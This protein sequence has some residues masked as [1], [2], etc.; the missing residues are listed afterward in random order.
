MMQILKMLWKLFR[1][2]GTKLLWLV[3]VFVK[4]RFYAM[5]WRYGT[6]M[7]LIVLTAALAWLVLR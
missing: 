4:A 2:Y 5:L 7:M 1:T 3:W 6:L